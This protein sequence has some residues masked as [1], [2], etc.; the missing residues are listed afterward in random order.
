MNSDTPFNL[1]I[2]TDS[3]KKVCLCSATSIIIIVL[4]VISPLSNFFKTSLLMKIFA[5]LL[6]IYTIYLN[7]H[8]T[9]LLRKANLFSIND[10]IKSQLNINIICSYVFTLFIGLL[11][12]FLV[13]SF[14]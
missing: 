3:T 9:D 11:I 1:T 12:I 4:F 2:F 5:L 10:N 14:F 13:K 7:I 8:Q 6:M